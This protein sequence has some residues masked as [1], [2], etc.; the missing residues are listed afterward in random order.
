MND[1]R[2]EAM[3]N[4]VWVMAI[5]NVAIHATILHKNILLVEP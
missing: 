2:Q 5:T 3:Q 1:G 4:M